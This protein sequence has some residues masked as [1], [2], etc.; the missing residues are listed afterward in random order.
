MARTAIGY[1]LAVGRVAVAP[2]KQIE[3]QIPRMKGQH[4]TNGC[5]RLTTIIHHLRQ[6]KMSRE[7]RYC[8][9][10]TVFPSEQLRHSKFYQATSK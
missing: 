3:L 2:G 9:L 4:L 7:Q 1:R 8:T 6:L 10:R 5:K